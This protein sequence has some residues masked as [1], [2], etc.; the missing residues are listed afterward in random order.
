M[1][2]AGPNS[3]RVSGRTLAAIKYGHG[4]EGR[5][6]TRYLPKGENQ[7]ETAV[8]KT[9]QAVDLNGIITNGINKLR[10]ASGHDRCR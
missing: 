9:P 1:R 4:L 3:R 5:S 8:A 6:A 10:I 2:G 7:M